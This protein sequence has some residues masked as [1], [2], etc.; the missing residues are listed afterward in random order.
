VSR[1]RTAT[2]SITLPDGYV[3]GLE[4]LVRMGLYSS[5]GEAIRAAIRD[6]LV[7][8]LRGLRRREEVLPQG[9]GPSSQREARPRLLAKPR[10]LRRG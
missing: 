4:A 2:I 1:K 7:R 10:R 5:R 9:V 3:E 6:L 8:E